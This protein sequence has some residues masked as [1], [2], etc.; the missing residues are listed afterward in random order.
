MVNLC[1]T[2]ILRSSKNQVT[3]GSGDSK[4]VHGSENARVS[5]ISLLRLQIFEMEFKDLRLSL[6]SISL[7]LGR[8]QNIKTSNLRYVRYLIFD[9]NSIVD[10]E[11]RKHVNTLIE[12]LSEM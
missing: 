2:R 12:E 10:F 6:N 3:F 9:K 1:D 11:T 7:K 4:Y 5:D 8:K